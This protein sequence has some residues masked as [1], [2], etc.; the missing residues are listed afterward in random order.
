MVASLATAVVLSCTVQAGRWI[1]PHLAVRTLF[2][3]GR[4]TCQ[5]TQP[6]QRTPL[7]PSSWLPAVDKSKGSKSVEVQRVWEVYDDR[8]Q[9]MSRHDALQLDE[10]LGGDDVSRAWLVWS[11]AAETALVDAYQF[12]GRSCTMQRLGSW[13]G[14]CFVQGCQAWWTR[15]GRLAVMLLML[16]MLPMSLCAVLS[17]MDPTG[18]DPAYCVAC[19]RF[20]MLRRYLAL[21]PSEVGRVYRLLELVS[22]ECPGHCPVHLLVASASEVGFRLDPLALGWCRLGLP[23]LSNLAGP[24]QHFRSSILDARQNKVAAELCDREGFRGGPLL[25]IHDSLQPLNSSHVRKRDKALLRSVMVGGVW[26][27]YLLGRFRG[28]PVPCWF[29]GAP[30]GDGHLFGECTLP[31]LI[32][33]REHPEFHD[34]MRFG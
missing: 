6:V 15:F 5:M 28:Q 1:A 14:D 10:V 8:L 2:Y 33:I 31:P 25:D 34:L 30:D 7:W 19:F 21:W 23:L 27:G 29:C 26:N 16:M 13:A 12:S 17:L 3:C 11:G 20:R 32:E 18:C 9:F 4:W 24:V 22:E